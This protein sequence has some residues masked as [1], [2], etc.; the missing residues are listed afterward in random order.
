MTR[1]PDDELPDWWTFPSQ[2]PVRKRVRK[3]LDKYL[4]EKKKRD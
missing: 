4:K 1:K 2:V 3:N